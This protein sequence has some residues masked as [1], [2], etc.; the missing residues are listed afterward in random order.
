[1]L[2]NLPAY[3]AW[4]R[5]A[6]IQVIGLATAL[7]T[8][9]LLPD[10]YSGYVSTG[11][12]VLTTIFHFLTPNAP[13]PGEAAASDEENYD[14]RSVVPSEWLPSETVTAGQVAAKN[15]IAAPPNS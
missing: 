8:L 13:A 7:L 11:V 10:P 1:M 9:G 4:T 14:D 3:L 2:K 5:K 12:A 15:E 6:I